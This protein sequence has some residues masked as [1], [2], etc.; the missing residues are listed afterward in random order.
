VKKT[1]HLDRS[2]VDFELELKAETALAIL[3]VS[4]HGDD[5]WLP[6]KALIEFTDNEDG[7][8][9]FTVTEELAFEKEL[10]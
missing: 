8:C 10:I 3:I 4:E 1:T 5:V 2:T 9:K 7:T 6:R